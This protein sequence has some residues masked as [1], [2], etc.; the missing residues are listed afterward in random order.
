MLISYNFLMKTKLIII[1]VITKE[2]LINYLSN[3]SLIIIIII[4]K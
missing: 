2:M 3:Y 4:I 1:K